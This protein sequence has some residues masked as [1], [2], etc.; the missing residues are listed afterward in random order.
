MTEDLLHKV[1]QIRVWK[2]ETVI[3]IENPDG[4]R[5]IG[6]GKQGAVFQIDERRCV[7]IYYHS[8][9]C[10]RELHTLK[11]GAK[12]GICPEIYYWDTQFIVME[13]LTAP[14]LFD[15]IQQNG[16]T[17]ELSERLV[18]L[19]DTFEQVGFN[20]FDHSARHIFIMPGDSMKVIDVVH[21]IKPTP[22]YLAKKLIGDMGMYG[23]DF[24]N[25]VRELSPKW[26]GHWSNHW[27]FEEVM[28]QLR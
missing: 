21:M 5:L 13:Y 24:V 26:Y 10:Q 2:P 17:R 28:S 6:K 27:E 8:K 14:T 23:H 15:Y 16:M 4:F 22:V 3:E 11:L 19:L 12:A 25:F 1:N 18:T 7:K 9:S 20:R